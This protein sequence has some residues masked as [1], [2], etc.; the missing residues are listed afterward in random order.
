MAQF[1]SLGC[2][3][4][5]NFM[6]LNLCI[7]TVDQEDEIGS[8][9]IGHY[10][11]F[12][13]F[14]DTIARHMRAADFPVLMTHS[15]CDGEWTVEQLPA[16]VRELETISA[17]FRTLPAEQ[18]QGA[19]DHTAEYRQDAESLYDCFHDVNGQNLFE[20]LISLCKQGISSQRPISFQ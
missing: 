15:D 3:R 16:L 12:G 7:F 13:C 19:F 17:K 11:D 2:L 5:S 6:G 14:R 1:F 4:V 9:D 18:P 20:A 10:S 8:C